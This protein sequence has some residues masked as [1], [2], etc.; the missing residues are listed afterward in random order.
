MV[1][2]PLKYQGAVSKSL[3]AEPWHG[4]T[5]WLK[6]QPD[7]AIRSGV[8]AVFD[9]NH[10]PLFEKFFFRH[11]PAKAVVVDDLDQLWP[12][13]EADPLFDMMTGAVRGFFLDYRGTPGF[14][15]LSVLDRGYRRS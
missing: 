8:N 10:N 5:N 3:Q 14:D 2:P 6:G 11:D 13:P 4:D 15:A 7:K 9:L 1:S 12:P